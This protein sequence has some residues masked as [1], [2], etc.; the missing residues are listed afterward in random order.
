MAD[1]NLIESEWAEEEKLFEMFIDLKSTFI[2]VDRN[3]I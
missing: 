2:K 1:K 3:I